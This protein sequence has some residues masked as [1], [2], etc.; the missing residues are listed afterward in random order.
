MFRMS[1]VSLTLFPTSYVMCES[2]A[3]CSQNLVMSRKGSLSRGNH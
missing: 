2:K 3:H 1:S